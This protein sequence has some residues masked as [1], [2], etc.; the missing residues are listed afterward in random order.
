MVTTGG[1]YQATD[2]VHST[3]TGTCIVYVV[4]NQPWHAWRYMYTRYGDA[5]VHNIVCTVH[6]QFVDLTP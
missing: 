1:G 2:I 4:I 6:S 5:C 3:L